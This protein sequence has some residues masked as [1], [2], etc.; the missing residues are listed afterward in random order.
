MKPAPGRAPP[1]AALPPPAPRGAHV[2][3]TAAQQ[4]ADA[5]GLKLVRQA[6]ELDRAKQH[7]EAIELGNKA[8]AIREK[9]LGPDHLSVLTTVKFVAELHEHKGDY[10][11]ALPLRERSAATTE[12]DK[13]PDAFETAVALDDLAR[14]CSRS[15]DHDR[16]LKLLERALAIHRKRRGPRDMMSTIVLSEIGSALLDKRDFDAAEARLAELLQ[17]YEAEH[18]HPTE[19]VIA[20]TL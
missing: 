1:A 14:V 18:D 12:K 3:L 20:Y 8:L 13:G 15:G 6:G 17:I 7:D 9:A 10:K 2:S 5:E 4:A 11:G 16:A 19:A